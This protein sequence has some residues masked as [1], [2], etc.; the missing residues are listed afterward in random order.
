M[1]FFLLFHLLILETNQ[2]IG[3]YD[4][5]NGENINGEKKS[6]IKNPTDRLVANARFMICWNRSIYDFLKIGRFGA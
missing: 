6:V 1:H 5:L 4:N 2:T 3:F